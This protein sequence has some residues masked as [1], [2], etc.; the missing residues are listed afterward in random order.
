MDETKTEAPLVRPFEEWARLKATPGWTLNA[1][2]VAWRWAIG[3]ELTER[4]YDDG[5]HRA[6]TTEIG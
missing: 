2:R 3:R 4:E 1:A 5:I 6:L